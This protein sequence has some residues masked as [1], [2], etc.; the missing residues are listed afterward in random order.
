MSKSAT[1]RRN[2]RNREKGKEGEREVVNMAKA[3]GLIAERAWTTAYSKYDKDRVIDVVIE[4]EP[5][6]VKR[7][8][9]FGRVFK[10]M[11]GVSGLFIRQAREEW[12]V[13]IPARQYF[14]LMQHATNK[15]RTGVSLQSIQLESLDLGPKRPYRKRKPVD[16]APPG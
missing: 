13:V 10:E 14:T 7:T 4:G 8:Q 2:R 9:G 11:L 16:K 6:Q 15:M 3:A 1:S 12:M 5:F